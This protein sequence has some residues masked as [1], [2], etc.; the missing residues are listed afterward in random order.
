MANV[1]ETLVATSPI[2]STPEKFYNFFKYDINDLVKVFPAC[3]KGVQVLEG[4]EATVGCV[5]LWSYVLGGI[6]M[7]AKERI[8]AINDAEKSLTIAVIGG[9]LM[10]LYK[11]FSFTLNA[12]EGLAK[13]TFA[14]EKLTILTPPPELYIPLAITITTLVDAF[15]LIN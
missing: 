2:K 1:I 12:S 7:T 6:P 3:F 13:W 11:S 15:L 4:E 8:E 14:F 9:D 5:K 10:R